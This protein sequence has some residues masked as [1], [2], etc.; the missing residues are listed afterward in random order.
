MPGPRPGTVWRGRLLSRT[1]VD[2]KKLATVS[3]RA[4]LIY[5]LL[6]P[7]HDGEG[8]VEADDLSMLT[9]CGRFALAKKWTLEAMSGA[10]EELVAAGLWQMSDGPHGDAAEFVGWE[11]HQRLDKIGRGSRLS[12]G[13]TTAI[14]GAT[15]AISGA[16][17]A[18]LRPRREEEVEDEVE[19]EEE[20]KRNGVPSLPRHD[21]SDIRAAYS[22]AYETVTKAPALLKPA[23]IQVIQSAIDLG[24]LERFPDLEAEFVRTLRGLQSKKLGMSCK[25]TINCAG[26]DWTKDEP[27]KRTAPVRREG[28]P[29]GPDPV[30]GRPYHPGA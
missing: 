10:R 26:G 16:T 9:G 23:D 18:Q 27:H 12:G 20:G 5:V 4:A 28:D 3:E 21:A 22:R 6:L 13:R 30:T 17:L 7:Q 25:A 11:D 8:M 24:T 2:S 15:P 14:S 29:F 1:I 19:G